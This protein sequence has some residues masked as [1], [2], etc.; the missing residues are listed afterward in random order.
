MEKMGLVKGKVWS[1]M[2][3]ERMVVNVKDR[4]LAIFLK[5]KKEFLTQRVSN[6]LPKS[7][8]SLGSN[9]IPALVHNP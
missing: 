5:V 9:C 8:F 7:W 1:K 4:Q 6:C 3:L 2:K